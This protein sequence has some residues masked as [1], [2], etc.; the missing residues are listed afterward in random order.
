MVS[1][2]T[3]AALL[4][5]SLPGSMLLSSCMSLCYLIIKAFMILFIY[6][7]IR[8][9]IMPLSGISLA[10]LCI[11]PPCVCLPIA[12]QLELKFSPITSFINVLLL[13]ACGHSLVTTA[14]QRPRR[15]QNGSLVSQVDL[16][17]PSVTLC[18]THCHHVGRLLVTTVPG[19]WKK[20]KKFS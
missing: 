17:D 9:P 18:W 2:H 20:K 14:H 15:K 13:F 19:L 16:L 5:L 3:A 1:P 10:A 12:V 7:L 4:L 8:C 11:T 6:M